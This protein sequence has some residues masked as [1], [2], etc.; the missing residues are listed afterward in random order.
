MCCI[1]ILI[2]TIIVYLFPVK[3]DVLMRG[4][5]RN[6]EDLITKLKLSN[7]ILEKYMLPKQYKQNRKYEVKYIALKNLTK[8]NQWLVNDTLFDVCF[9]D[10]D[11]DICKKIYNRKKQY[12]NYKDLIIAIDKNGYNNQIPILVNQEWTIIDGYHRT[13]YLIKRNV[14]RDTK[15]LV[16]RIFE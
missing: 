6:E 13:K 10:Y 8:K 16:L 2:S 11:T 15:I 5:Y 14:D 4:Y 1:C 12:T 3:K 9:D 7:I